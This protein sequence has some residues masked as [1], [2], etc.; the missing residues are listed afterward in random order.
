MIVLSGGDLFKE[1][2]SNSV[3]CRQVSAINGKISE[4]YLHTENFSW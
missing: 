2:V 4:I 1:Q 3:A